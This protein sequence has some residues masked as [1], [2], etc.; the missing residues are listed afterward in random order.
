MRA[1][2]MTG[3]ETA[4]MIPL[5]MSGSDMR[6]TPPCARMSAGTRSSA[7]TATA[8]A[9][10]AILACSAVTTSM[11]TPP[12]SISAM[13][14]LTRAV[15]TACCS[16]KGSCCSDMAPS[17]RATGEPGRRG[18]QSAGDPVAWRRP[19]STVERRALR[20]QDHPGIPGDQRERLAVRHLQRRPVGGLRPGPGAVYA[21]AVPEDGDRPAARRIGELRRVPVDVGVLRVRRD[22]AELDDDVR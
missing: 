17:L 9:S 10:S 8:P 4:A 22:V 21:P 13:P 16:D 15:P 11:M 5:I 1:F 2:A 7:I 19:A 6:E 12:L 18:R 20:R 14:R 3:I